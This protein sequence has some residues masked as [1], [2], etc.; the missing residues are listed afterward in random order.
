MVVVV[1]AMLGFGG[2]GS[3]HGN[4]ETRDHLDTGT[5]DLPHSFLL[6]TQHTHTHNMT[7]TL[8]FRGTLEGKESLQY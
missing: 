5:P 6:Y 2:S 1:V 4:A 3:G 8:A 7:D